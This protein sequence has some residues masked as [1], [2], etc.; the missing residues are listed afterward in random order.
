MDFDFKKRFFLALFST[1]INSSVIASGVVIIPLYATQ[2]LDVNQAL[3]ML[4]LG[5]IGGM[6]PD[7][8]SDSSKPVT[9]TFRFISI[10]FPLIVLLLFAKKVALLYMI[11]FWIFAF[12][13]LDL[14]FF[15]IL[16]PST[17]H[18][19][20]FHSIP[21]G[22]LVGIIGYIIAKD[23]L[24][25]SNTTATLSGFFLFYGYINHLI[26]DELY[27]VNALGFRLKRSFG[28]ALKLWSKKNHLGFVFLY[29]LIAVLLY[30]SHIDFSLLNKLFKTVLEIRLI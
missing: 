20:I 11:L 6:L 2:V 12:L 14:I 27:S 17:T 10:I 18:R 8:D 16:L 28:T 15:K 9:L 26:L 1:H 21:M 24:H 29:T 22:V 30:F 7:L 13:S 3:S 4:F 19:G 25:T 5:I 23:M